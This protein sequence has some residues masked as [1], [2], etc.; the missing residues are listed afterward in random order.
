MSTLK[1]QALLVSLSITKPQMTKKDHKG[2]FAA[3]AATNALN[4]GAYIKRLFPK[5]LIDPITSIEGE[6]RSYLYAYTVPWNKGSQLLPSK[7][8][9]VFA[10]QMAKHE[11]MFDQAV[12]V[13]LNNFVQVMTEAEQAQGDMF[14]ANEYPDLSEL[15]SR[16]SMHTRYFPIADMSDFRLEIEKEALADVKQQVR[17]SIESAL[18]E[19]MKEPYE[20]LFN[21]VS[22]IATQCSEPK[23]RIH[24]SLMENLD[25]LLDI[26]PDL[27]FTNDR[28]L[29]AL[30]EQCRTN[31]SVMP[32]TLRVEPGIR[33]N[34]AK[35]AKEIADTMRAFM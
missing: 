4:A 12:V 11:L 5:H 31:I 29:A 7:R 22:R 35:Q 14:N 24:D 30:L 26:L 33:A 17:A 1:T 23:A 34:V 10:A 3:E 9:M 15:R 2:T 19:S 25:E 13:F 18:T 20:R 16:F 21:A 32:E 8:Y 27:N 6:A 28:N